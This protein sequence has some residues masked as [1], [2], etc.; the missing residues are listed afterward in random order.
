MDH[1]SYI[2]IGVIIC[3]FV[4]NAAYLKGTFSKSIENCE[5]DIEI[6]Q[7][8]LKGKQD[9]E[10]CKNIRDECHLNNLNLFKKAGV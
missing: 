7:T 3:G 2:T 8:D 9:K 4:G 5:K 10:T 6:I 1:Q